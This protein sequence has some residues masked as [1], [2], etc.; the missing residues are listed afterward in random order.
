MEK[1]TQIKKIKV[2]GELKASKRKAKAVFSFLDTIVHEAPDF[3]LNSFAY[4]SCKNTDSLSLALLDEKWRFSTNENVNIRLASSFDWLNNSNNIVTADSIFSPQFA[5][6]NENNCV[7]NAGV[8][9]YIANVNLSETA[10]WFIHT[11]ATSVKHQF[12]GFGEAENCLVDTNAILDASLCSSRVRVA[13]ESRFPNY[14][15][16]YSA[17]DIEPSI[18][19]CQQDKANSVS[20]YTDYNSKIAY[21]ETELLTYFSTEHFAKTQYE[22]FTDDNYFSSN[23]FYEACIARIKKFESYENY[24]I[25]EYLRKMLKKV[26]RLTKILF[27]LSRTCRAINIRNIIRR[28]IKN[29]HGCTSDEDELSGFIQVIIKYLIHL[30]LIVNYE[31]GN[32]RPAY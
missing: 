16:G 6:S 3:S 1:K 4:L 27:S 8:S 18:L 20:I 17:S 25:V 14:Y 31:K 13:E 2:A 21:S 30:K 32:Y 5:F 29:L 19:A 24:E 9:P 12:Y 10:D 26:K 15:S 28:R 22:K 7:V 23:Y 11:G